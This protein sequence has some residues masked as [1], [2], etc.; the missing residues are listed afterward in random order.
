MK[1]EFWKT[2][3]RIAITWTIE[4]I[5]VCA[6]FYVFTK[7]R[8]P[9]NPNLSDT[10]PS[11]VYVNNNETLSAA[12]RNTL[13]SKAT[14]P[15]L[16]QQYSSNTV[17]STTATSWADTDM[18]ITTTTPAGHI[19][20]LMNWS[21]WTSVAWTVFYIFNIDGTDVVTSSAWNT[22]INQTWTPVWKNV[23]ISRLANVSAW[24]H[25]FKVRRKTNWGTA[26]M[27]EN[28]WRHNRQFQAIV[29]P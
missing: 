13:A 8:Q 28:I 9:T 4:L 5:I 17:L 16:S 24:S 29:L 22:H 7:A 14:A 25:T 3:K 6:W 15:A 10:T 12:K 26:Y 1:K 2:T 21:T 19:L 20:L 18:T 11:A 27:D 23:S